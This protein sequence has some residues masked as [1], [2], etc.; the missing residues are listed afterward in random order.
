MAIDQIACQKCG[1][2]LTSHL[3]CF[4]C[5]AIQ[6]ISREINY[7][8]VLGIYI[9]YEVDEEELEDKYQNLSLQLHPDFF[10]SASESEKSL[11]EKSSAL[12]N[13]AYKTL[14]EPILRA[15]YLI[16]FFSQNK[17]LDERLLPEGFLAEMFSM[18][19]KLDEILE[20]DDESSILAMKE[21]LYVRREK[22]ESE[23]VPLFKK[24][25]KSQNDYNLL[26]QLQINLNAER[27]LKRLLDRI[28]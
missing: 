19:E 10:E 15:G 16:D 21:N 20:S 17:K 3:F 18:Q 13:T 6:S 27:Y 5:K 12:L 22:I 8:E 26:Q 25:E 11:S 28:N 9:G 14:S 2:S 7:F 4:S 24:L 1:S 23:F